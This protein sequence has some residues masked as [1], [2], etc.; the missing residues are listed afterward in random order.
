MFDEIRS[1]QDTRYVSASEAMWR[2]LKNK[3]HDRSHS[4]MRLPAHLP[5]EKQIR[6]EEGNE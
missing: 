1:Y 5:N 6:F 2:L 3:M 4:V